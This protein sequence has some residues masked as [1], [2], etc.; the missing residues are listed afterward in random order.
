MSAQSWH[1]CPR[2]GDGSEADPFRPTCTPD[3]GGWVDLGGDGFLV[4]AAAC[5]GGE[6]LTAE[7]AA[8]RIAGAT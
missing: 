1:I 4:P 2:C 6:L 7:Q 3:G 8:A 5:E